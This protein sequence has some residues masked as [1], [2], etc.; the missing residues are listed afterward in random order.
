MSVIMDSLKKAKAKKSEVEPEQG[1]KIEKKAAVGPANIMVFA[2]VFILA[3]AII[4]VLFARLNVNIKSVAQSNSTLEER[5]GS[6][7]NT[8]Q[9]SSE[10]LKALSGQIKDVTENMV[11]L[12][13]KII[14]SED[15]A[16][17]FLSEI[18]GMKGTLTSMQQEYGPLSAQVQELR[19]NIGILAARTAGK[20]EGHEN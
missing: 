10:E 7:E 2:G 20:R 14:L 18:E 5:I 3:I 1:I 19:K 13:K 8:L 15:S 11:S 17:S 12:E 16:K 4:L 6:V 9:N